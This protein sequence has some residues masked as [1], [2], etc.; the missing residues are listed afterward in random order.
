M[1]QRT[2]KGYL[3]DLDGTIYRGGEVIP[4]AVDFIARLTAQGIP[5]LYVTNNS[6]MT[7]QQLADKVQ[8]MGIPTK[9]EQFFTSSM[10]VAET[11][12]KMEDERQERRQA[13][14]LAI[15]ETGL[16]TALAEKGIA[17]TDKAPADYVVVGIDRSF[18]YEKMK[19]ATLAIYGGARFLSTNCDRAIPTE[20]G[21]VPGNGALTASIAY[22]TNQQPL[23][24][25]K[26]EE[27]IIKLALERLGL[28]AEDVMMVGD[29][30][31]TDIACGENGGVD[32][33]LVYTG[34]SRAEHIETSRVKPTY[35][36]QSL[37]EWTV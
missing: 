18:S 34:F 33:L 12:R 4:E 22:A 35:T 27:T 14:V 26:P 29:N 13:T 20:E 36:I 7:P 2:Y 30:L 19:Q 9:P 24:V 31:E 5:Y 8:T 16:C 11:V 10:A 23:Y 17:V 1:Q 37:T 28:A 21:L 6:S 25:G 3:L 15:G 32:T